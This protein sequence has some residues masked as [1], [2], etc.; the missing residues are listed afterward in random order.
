V[1]RKLEVEA[2][3][4][5][6]AALEALLRER[7]E[8]EDPVGHYQY[9]HRLNELRDYLDELTTAPDLT[10]SVALFFAGEPVIGSRGVRADFASRAVGIFQDIVA[11]RFA[12]MS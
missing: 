11:K 8:D 6:A 10:A 9:T 2:M 7:T 12:T 1:I 4:A 5:E 3:S